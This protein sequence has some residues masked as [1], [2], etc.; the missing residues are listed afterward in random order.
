ME[1]Y[2]AI[3]GL[4]VTSRGYIQNGLSLV[5]VVTTIKEGG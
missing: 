5:V 4:V 1:T 3:G 2:R